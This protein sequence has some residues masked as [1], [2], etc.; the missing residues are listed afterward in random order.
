M[1]REM[2]AAQGAYLDYLRE[3]RLDP[4][5]SDVERLQDDLKAA[6]RE[7]LWWIAWTR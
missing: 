5:G 4:D 2:S 1:N 6:K 3:I 7:G